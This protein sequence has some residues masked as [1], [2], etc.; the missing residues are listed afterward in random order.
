M[1]LNTGF[2]GFD[3][4]ES[5]R[6]ISA[7]SQVKKAE[8][9]EGEQNVLLRAPHARAK[10][11][12]RK[13]VRLYNARAFLTDEKDRTGWEKAGAKIEGGYEDFFEESDLIVVGTPAGHEAPYVEAGIAHNRSMMLMGGANRPEILQELEKNGVDVPDKI[14]EDLGREFFFG[15]E[16]YEKFLKAKSRLVQCTSCNTTAMCRATLAARPLGLKAILG[17]L[18][19]RQGDPHNIVKV[20]PNAISFGQGVGHQGKDAGTVFKDVRYSVRASKVPTTI[21]HVHHLNLVFEGSISPQDLVEQF[22]KTRRIVIIPYEDAGKTHE[23]TSEILEAFLSPF[24]RPISPEIFE[25]LISDAVIH[26]E[27]GKYTILQIVMMVEQMSLPV[28]NYVE[29]YLMFSGYSADQVHSRVDKG[30]GCVH[31]VWPDQLSI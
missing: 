16:N 7:A 23:W 15:L 26:F 18:D 8:G 14:R 25:L 20:S 31:G 4:T 27:L 12:L 30:L 9:I 10:S 22:A 17:N 1:K 28:P 24:E 6:A 2:I 29:A 3:G 11:M 19:R 5:K 21:P 13:F